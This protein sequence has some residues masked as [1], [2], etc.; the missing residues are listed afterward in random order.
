MRVE[1]L[2]LEGVLLLEPRR[3]QDARG[4][5]FESWN[6][7]TLEAAGLPVAFV[8]DNVSHSRRGVLRGLHFQH[9]N[10]QGKLITVVHGSV[11]D[12]AV[13]VRPASPSFG[14]WLGVE[15]AAA[16]GRQLW[17]PPGFAHG[18]QALEDDTVVTY[19]CTSHYSPADEI[20]LR[21]N[22]P[23]LGIT[24]PLADPI[25]SPKDAQAQGLRA[26]AQRFG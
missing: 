5:F 23:E 11:Y 8:Q 24:W 3:F 15:L 21:W 1:Q 2:A 6:R 25:V 13:D 12:V 4:W 19:K 22:D 18:F 7:A 16:S 9:P 10:A 14:Q 17:V 26:L 20:T